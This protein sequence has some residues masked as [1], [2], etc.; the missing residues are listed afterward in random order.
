MAQ[1]NEEG[2]P[3][4]I[5]DRAR[6]LLEAKMRGGRAEMERVYDEM[7]P[8]SQGEASLEKDVDAEVKEG[9]Q[10]VP[11]ARGAVE[12]SPE[13]R[14]SASSEDLISRY[15]VEGNPSDLG[16]IIIMLWPGLRLPGALPQQEETSP[17]SVEPG[18]HRKSRIRDVTD[19]YLGWGFQIGWADQFQRSRVRGG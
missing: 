2:R 3:E 17:P 5:A 16:G 14:T 8:E 13:Q 1:E 18:Q 10:S 15:I 12:R 7:Y 19:Q 11:E 4:T 6:R 9:E